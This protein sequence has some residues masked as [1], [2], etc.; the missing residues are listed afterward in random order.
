MP[1]T[2]GTQ[3]VLDT[4]DKDQDT[5][6]GKSN[7]TGKSSDRIDRVLSDLKSSNDDGDKGGDKD[8]DGDADKDG[9]ESV[10][11]DADPQSKRMRDDYLSKTAKLAE[12][13][14]ALADERAALAAER[15][16]WE[17]SRKQAQ[18]PKEE[19]KG[20]KKQAEFFDGFHNPDP[21]TISTEYEGEQEIVKGLQS[22]AKHS[23][24]LEARLADLEKKLEKL[25]EIEGTVDRLGQAEVSVA[26][27]H[28][29]DCVREAAT[30][31]SK[32]LGIE[33][34][35]EQV[36]E[37]VDKYGMSLFDPDKEEFTSS[38]ALDAFEIAYKR[39]ARALAETKSRTNGHAGND[40]AKKKSPPDMGS[41]SLEGSDK[42]PQ[43]REGK[44]IRDLLEA[45]ARRG[46][47]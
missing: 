36:M 44:V 8:A 47:G 2:E 43:D 19:D 25:P 17:E 16:A 34:T 6:G 31:A 10:G 1:E 46:R 27:Q 11:E 3:A 22:V 23:T 15:A 45:R 42:E 28:I 13:R 9:I 24:G 30:K 14:Q 4:P 7:D 32:D 39:N 38:V 41:G 5:Q 21:D 26:A 35:A 33:V 12:D 40:E 18:P 29:V 37:A 20:T